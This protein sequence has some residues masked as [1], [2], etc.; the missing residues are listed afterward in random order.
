MIERSKSMKNSDRC[1]V[2]LMFSLLIL[3]S[4]ASIGV[5]DLAQEGVV[6]D[7][8]VKVVGDGLIEKH[9]FMIYGFS[10]VSNQGISITVENLS[11][12]PVVINWDKSSISYEDK[13]SGVFISGQKFITAGTSITPLTLPAN[14][15][16]SIEIYPADN[17]SYNE[18]KM[19][20]EIKNM[21]LG[22]Y[23]TLT[24][25]LNYE[26]NKESKFISLK[27]LPKNGSIKWGF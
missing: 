8:V 20:W 26:Y 24:L 5:F 15:K 13:T 7:N 12:E 2:L 14:G 4:C 11:N 23:R 27:A 21:G 18:K 9:T 6:S 10:L 16:K 19:D 25:T 3:T 17:V 1:L 22:K